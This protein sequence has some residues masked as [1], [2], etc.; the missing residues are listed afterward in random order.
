MLSRRSLYK[1]HMSDI[2]NAARPE[3]RQ[4]CQGAVFELDPVKL[5][6]R[7]A[8]ARNSVLD[9]IEEGHSKSNGEQAAPRDAL[10]MLDSLHRITE[11]Q[12]GYQSKAS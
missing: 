7:I 2:S 12:D 9:R 10:A 5:L 6:E 1:E 3:W 11:H 8:L 4:L